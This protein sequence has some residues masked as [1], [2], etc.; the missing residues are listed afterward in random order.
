[1]AVN[2][3]WK[4]QSGTV[5][6][7]DYTYNFYEGNAFMIMLDEFKN[8]NTGE[9]VYNKVCCF[10]DKNHAKRSLG[11]VKGSDDV[12]EGRVKKMTIFMNHCH[13]WKDII[14]LFT[15]AYP[16]IEITILPQKPEVAE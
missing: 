2:W 9:D 14:E 1:M 16:N 11:L 12:F 5:T 13:Y 10:L 6:I 7:S 8:K 15:K 3:Q 4:N